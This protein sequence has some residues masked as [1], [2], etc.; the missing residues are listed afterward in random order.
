MLIIGKKKADYKGKI[1]IDEYKEV[2]RFFE[3]WS[4]IEELI[5]SKYRYGN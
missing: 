3:E 5:F 1:I 2:I 4:N